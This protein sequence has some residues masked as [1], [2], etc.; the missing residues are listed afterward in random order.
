MLVGFFL[1]GVLIGAMGWVE[2]E[3]FLLWLMIGAVNVLLMMKFDFI[4]YK[5]F[6]SDLGGD[7]M[8]VGLVWLS[9]W[10]SGLMLLASTKI[11]MNHGKFCEIVA[12][13]CFLLLLVFFSLDLF[14]FYIAFEGVLIPTL[15]LIVGW[16]YQPERLQAGIYLIFYTVCA[17]LPLLMVILWWDFFWG[18]SGNVLLSV[19]TS[20]EYSLGGLIYFGGVLAFLVSMP[21]FMFHLWLPSAHVEAPISGSMVLAGVIKDSGMWNY[22]V[23]SY[24]CYLDEGTK[25]WIWVGGSLGGGVIL[26]LTCL[27]QSDLKSLVAYSSV[28]HMGLVIGGIM[29]LSVVGFVGSYILMVGHGLCS[30]GLFCL[31]NLAYERVSS[32][33]V[34]LNSGLMTLMPTGGLMWFLLVSS[35]MA[36]PPSLNLIG[37]IMLLSS[38]LFWCGISLVGLMMVG[39]LSAAYSL[40]MFTSCQHGSIMGGVL[41][42]GGLKGKEFLLVILHWVPLNVM[43]MK[44]EVF[45]F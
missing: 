37:E 16:G 23:S 29:S 43:V 1:F 42:C 3:F 20:V 8:S 28:V 31:V 36:A 41:G 26:S 45:M 38:M 44:S 4:D 5:V 25:F 34:L 12:L 7:L 11:L 14:G 40:Y 21:M 17:S 13:L 6:S 35:N 10:I 30:S 18:N 27:R 33:M 2:W 39:I 32:R 22:T 19:G 15:V 9:I 24:L